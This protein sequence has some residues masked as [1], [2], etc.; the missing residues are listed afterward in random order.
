MSTVDFI[1][2]Y[3]PRLLGGFLVTIELF[4][5]ASALGLL[6]ALAATT[7]H[8]LL[9]RAA[10]SVV[11]GYLF[12]FRGSPLLVQAF[13]LYYGA[14]QFRAELHDLGLWFL[15]QDA[16]WCG[17]IAIS[18]NTAAYT[19]ALL[20]GALRS[21]PRGIADAC[22]SLGLSRWL[23][24]R[25]VTLPHAARLAFPA[26]GNELITTLK[27]TA[28]L[29]IIS[30]N[31][32]LSQARLAFSRTFALEAFITAAVIYLL[33]TIALSACLSLLARRLN[34]TFNRPSGGPS[35]LSSAVLEHT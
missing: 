14:G 26:Y 32:L 6:I 10:R 24:Y 7:A 23:R 33:A 13:L 34:R 16:F 3:L 27:G 9:G 22:S 25:L 11:G 31:E 1:A 21:V 17:L 12:V 35:V 2:R 29:S 28:V 5:L 20:I 15:F 8:H 18:L 30:V 4:A 19:T